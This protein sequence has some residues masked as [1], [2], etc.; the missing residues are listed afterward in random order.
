MKIREILGWL[1]AAG[2]MVAFAAGYSPLGKTISGDVR[3]VDGDSLHWATPRFAC[4]ASTRSRD[5]RFACEMEAPGAAA[6]RPRT[7]CAS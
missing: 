7:S 3:V 4:L 5:A 2:A 6:K 1:I